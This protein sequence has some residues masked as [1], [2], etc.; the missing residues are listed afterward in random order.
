MHQLQRAQ[1][2]HQAHLLWQ[3]HKVFLAGPLFRGQLSGE[4]M[5]G[6]IAAALSCPP[7]FS[8]PQCIVKLFITK[9]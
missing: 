2:E 4:S 3:G 6:Q 7:H 8:W 1:P 9:S 5:I